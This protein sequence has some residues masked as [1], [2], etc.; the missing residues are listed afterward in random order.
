MKSL[1]LVM[2]AT[3]A[4]PAPLLPPYGSDTVVIKAAH[5]HLGDGNVES[6]GVVVIRDGKI[7][8]AG[9]DPGMPLGSR[10]IE[11]GE[12]SSITPGLID[13][14]CQLGTS[15]LIGWSEQL[16][17]VVPQVDLSQA[18]DHYSRD[19]EEL[20]REGVTTICL[21]PEAAS[22]VGG[23]GISFKTAGPPAG[24]M[25]PAAPFVKANLGPETVFRAG[26]NTTPFGQSVSFYARRPTT[27]MGSAWVFRKA[28]YDALEY[29]SKGT[30]SQ[31]PA[32][33]AVLAEVL[34]GKV[35]LRMQ[36]REAHDFFTCDRLA[37][38]FGLTFT[39]EYATE[40]FQCLDLLAE[41]KIPVIYG[42]V[43]PSAGLSTGF[44]DPGDLCLTTPVKL[45]ERGIAFCLTAADQKGENG[46]CHQAGLAIRHGLEETEA[47]R[48]VTSVPAQFLGV[49]KRVG[50]LKPD[51]DAD[52]VVWDGPPLFDTSRVKAVL[53]LG[54]TVH[55]PDGLFDAGK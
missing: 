35:G 25:L 48:A 2:L 31:D 53:I 52:L 3:L 9:K 39:L 16:S 51:L 11:C 24:R 20:A 14:A 40:A 36:A 33:M 50:A 19:L 1:S 15:T 21:T 49:E 7:I 34:D 45:K 17:E 6:P 22:V 4:E 44:N 8:A 55:D 18:V 30:T 28:F 26:S 38:E 37:S 42:P 46:L 41:R 29:R 13:A 12:A 43:D 5:V 23:K 54:Q 32:V 27:R 10:V 47:L